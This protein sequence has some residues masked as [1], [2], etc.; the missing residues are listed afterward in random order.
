MSGG[1]GLQGLTHNGLG[2]LQA[3]ALEGVLHLEIVQKLVDAVDRIPGQELAQLLVAFRD[4]LP[5]QLQGQGQADPADPAVGYIEVSPQGMGQS[6]DHPESGGGKGHPGQ[7]ASQQQILGV[8]SAGVLVNL[9][10]GGRNQAAALA[11]EHAGE[12]RG[13]R[14]QQRLHRL[15]QG[16]HPGV[17]DCPS[18]AGGQKIRVEQDP[19]R[20]HPG[21]PY[22]FLLAR[23]P[24]DEDGD[25]GC[26][27]SGPGGCRSREKGQARRFHG[28][29]GMM[30]RGAGPGVAEPG[31]GLGQIEHAA[32]AQSTDPGGIELPGP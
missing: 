27:G 18:G 9:R 26:L 3:H 16:V 22:R 15:G 23:G 21:G 12:S 13:A 2:V 17:G 4:G 10:K 29:P 11:C 7:E 24:V 5:V 32:A 8:F 31:T 30:L 28:Q 14:A 6:V 20:E 25:P 19:R 1:T